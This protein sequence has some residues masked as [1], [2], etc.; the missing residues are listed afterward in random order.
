MPQRKK[1]LNVEPNG[2][3]PLKKKAL[4]IGVEFT[5]NVSKPIDSSMEELKNLAE[6][7]HYNPIATVFQKRIIVNPKTFIGKGKVEEVGRIILHH[8]V[9]IVIF[10]ENL[11]PTQNKNLENKEYSLPSG[12]KWAPVF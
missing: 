7:A 10:D 5:S 4:L 3:K 11:S 2:S 1:P 12:R 6:T 8:S 9:D